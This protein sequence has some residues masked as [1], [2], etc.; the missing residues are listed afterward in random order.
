M[1]PS[2]SRGRAPAPGR[3]LSVRFA[4]ALSCLLCR[5]PWRRVAPAARSARFAL[6][7]FSPSPAASLRPGGAH[8]C[9]RSGASLRRP[10]AILGK[11]ARAIHGPLRTFCRPRSAPRPARLSGS[12]A[13]DGTPARA[14]LRAAGRAAPTFARARPLRSLSLAHK[15][16][17]QTFK[18]T[19]VLILWIKF[20]VI[21]H[22]ADFHPHQHE[23]FPP[24]CPFIPSLSTPYSQV[25]NSPSPCVSA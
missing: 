1:F 9:A 13:G 2:Q 11:N 12:R 21:H 10:G 3:R 15:T 24:F 16:T 17:E 25:I 20:E 14:A 7:R 18:I 19:N 6:S 4:V 23:S 5:H 22:S 8:P